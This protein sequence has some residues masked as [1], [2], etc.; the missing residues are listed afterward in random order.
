MEIADL[1][2]NDFN[3]EGLYLIF[4][5]S[6]RIV[7][8]KEKIEQFASL[9]LDDP[10][11]V[12]LSCKEAVDFHNCAICPKKGTGEFCVALR[13]TLPFLGMIDRY[14]SF[15][16][17]IA[18]FKEKNSELLHVRSTTM[19]RALQYLSVLSLIHYCEVGKGYAKYFLGV[20]PLMDLQG[21]AER[22]YLNIYWQCRGDAPRMK[23]VIEK[24]VA[25]ITCTSKCQH[26]RLATIC[27][28][29]AF[30]NAFVLTRVVADLILM[31][32]D[33]SIQKAFNDFEGEHG[34][35]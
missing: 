27:K 9:F 19:E 29:D 14:V 21:V 20:M 16:K 32:D 4:P 18:V 30:L 34:N 11:K 12:P 13:P 35:I 23:A 2:L 7:L 28:N 31:M 3:D 17:V 15:D 1:S 25:E 8:T 24:F 26:S 33:E 10:E 22:I 6:F 5:D